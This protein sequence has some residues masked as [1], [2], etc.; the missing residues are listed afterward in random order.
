MSSILNGVAIG[1]VHRVETHDPT[2]AES[3]H[4]LEQEICVAA[5]SVL[6]QMHV[7]DRAEAQKEDPALSAVLDWLAGPEEN[8]FKGLLWKSMPPAKKAK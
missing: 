2:M 1:A 5:G 3:D 8:R 6:I 7:M 4:H